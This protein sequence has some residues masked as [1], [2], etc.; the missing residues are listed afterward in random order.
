[1][2]TAEGYETHFGT[3]HIGH[4]LLT[5]LLLPLLEKIVALPGAD[6]RIVN[7]SSAAQAM[8]IG[9]GIPYDET[10][11]D[12]SARHRYGWY[13][14]SKLANVMH[15]AE[16]AKRHPGITS[17][18]VHPGR[19]GT[20]LLNGYFKKMSGMAMFQK[21]YDWLV[22]PLTVEQGALSQLWAATW[23]KEDVKSGGYYT[24]VGYDGKDRV[25]KTA[26]NEKATEKLWEWQED[27][28]KKLG[29]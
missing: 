7:V 23:K 17:V 20:T 27:E 6:V 3:N 2:T 14:S 9:G 19:V 4:A 8:A 10:K 12:G 5:K 13:G 16:L 24:P 1:M 11:S 21:F 18:S 15:A 28:F 25:N 22:G 26:T 29:Y